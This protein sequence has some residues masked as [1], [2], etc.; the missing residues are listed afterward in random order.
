MRLE[1]EFEALP[2]PAPDALVKPLR[3]GRD[4]KVGKALAD[5]FPFE[6]LELPLP[7]HDGRVRMSG[8]SSWLRAS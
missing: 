7:P 1:N 3:E 4:G 6:L 8:N 2:V 5:D